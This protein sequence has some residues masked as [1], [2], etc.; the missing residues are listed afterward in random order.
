MIQKRVIPILLLKDGGLVKTQQ[1]KNPRYIG[2]PINAVRLF[3][4]KEVDELVV[5]NISSG[6][7]KNEPDYELLER[8]AGEAFMP[9]AFGGGVT[10]SQQV[11]KLLR[12]GFEKIVL[13][14]VLFEN[15]ELLKELSKEYGATTLVVAVDVK[16]NFLGRYEVYSESGQKKQ[17]GSLTDTCLKWQD[18]GA[19]ELLLHA[20]D[21]DGSMKGYDLSL[22]EMVAGKLS[23]PVIAAGGAGSLKDIE[24]AH[25]KT[26]AAAFGAGSIF[27]FHGP[28]KAVLISYP[29]YNQLKTLFEKA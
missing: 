6:R 2:D 3:N 15:P 20:I 26:H 25:Q 4:D 28:H 9:V 21:R 1:F 18:Y 24:L 16:K 8:I 23:I 10:N 19:G 13:N 14:S 11:R 17:P 22:I 5:L 7:N 29:N 12:L 27:V